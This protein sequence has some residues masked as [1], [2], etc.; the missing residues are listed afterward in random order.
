MAEAW[1]QYNSHETGDYV[2][3]CLWLGAF[4]V[5]CEKCKTNWS[6]GHTYPMGDEKYYGFKRKGMDAFF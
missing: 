2:M 1:E 5:K 3:F 4:D 6:M